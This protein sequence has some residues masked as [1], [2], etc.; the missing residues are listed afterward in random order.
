M[1]TILCNSIELIQNHMQ[2]KNFVKYVRTRSKK[3]VLNRKIIKMSQ[4][5]E[6]KTFSNKS[7]SLTPSE[8]QPNIAN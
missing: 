5:N 3:Y 1:F 2:V 7:G 4:K 6:N 8:H